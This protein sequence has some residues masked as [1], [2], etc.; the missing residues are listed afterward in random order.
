MTKEKDINLNKKEKEKNV[1]INIGIVLNKNG[2]VLIIKR[3]NPE[4]TKSGK[5]LVWVFP[6]GKQEE[7]E[8]RQESVE[9]EV[10]V[11]TG[12]K[13]RAERELHLR[14]HPDANLMMAYHYCVLESET[15]VQ[16]I[17]E[18]DEVEEVKWVKPQEL[19]Q[20]FS[21]DIDPEVKK[22]LKI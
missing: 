13:V 17:E 3:K 7:N 18:I 19:A 12:Y 4:I 21:T 15:P 10:L 11:E 5:K 2:D 20:Y 9:K 22:I 14:I 1:F 6:G 16:P 8:T